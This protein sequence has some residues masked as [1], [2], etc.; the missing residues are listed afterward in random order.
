MSQ[1]SILT[2]ENFTGI[3][4]EVPSHSLQDNEL[5]SCT[6]F[7]VGEG[8]ELKKRT[9]W[10]QTHDGVT[11]GANPVI[12]LGLFKTDTIT[13]LIAKAG[14][15]LYYSTDG[16]NW[17]LIGGGPWG[18][19]ESAVQYT[20]RFYIVRSDNT[21]IVWDGLNAAAI[22]GSPAGTHCR[23][24]KDRLFVL[25]TLG[26]LPSRFYFSLI[27]DFTS[28]GWVSTNFIDISPGD[29][30]VL[31]VAVT[32]QDQLFLFKARSIWSL[33]VQGDPSGW[34]LRNFSR[35]T[36]CISK[37]TPREVEGVT[38]FVGARGIYIFDGVSIS[39]ISRNIDS[40]FLKQ[41]TDK[42]SLNKA[43]SFYWQD[44]YVAV[45]Q[46]VETVITWQNFELSSWEN[47]NQ[48]WEGG[49]QHTF[50][51]YHIKSKSWTQ[52]KPDPGINPHIFVEVDITLVFRGVF[53]GERSATG[54]VLKYGD[55][56]YT[57]NNVSYLATFSTKTF[58]FDS[59][60]ASKR[61]KWL[62]VK[63]VAVGE[64]VVS[65]IIDSERQKDS[66]LIAEG[67]KLI[68][69]HLGPG[70]F[71]LWRFVYSATH[72]NAI[73]FYSVSVALHRKKAVV[74]SAS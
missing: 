34:V 66:Q 64:F 52:W 46:T 35:E 5:T 56:V 48:V 36:G 44:A 54:R 68:T 30:D 47:V 3:N 38:Y 29:G 18:N 16:T 24:H 65:S 19:T 17:T 49:I 63:Q 71:K 22:T 31:V 20:N 21:I 1:E 41:L 9:G 57:D 61:G 14:D 32:V 37:Y 13:Q 33:L 60:F 11:L 28:T 10:K 74:A 70:Y 67:S 15:N 40:I 39:R 59:P 73:T 45:I 4:T 8:G 2:I 58:D 25:N 27:A 23:V 50:Y 7:N 53:S 51:T 12:I 26:S 55:V 43:S 69:K 62:A 72:P 42:G 6:N